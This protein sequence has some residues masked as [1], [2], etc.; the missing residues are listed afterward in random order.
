MPPHH[1][2]TISKDFAWNF[3][4]GSPVY[5]VIMHKKFKLIFYGLVC[6]A[7]QIIYIA[8]YAQQNEARNILLEFWMFAGASG[9]K[10]L[11]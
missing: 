6:A 8:Q 10:I 2:E 7:N 9:S 5:N 3:A 11:N 1:R 4:N